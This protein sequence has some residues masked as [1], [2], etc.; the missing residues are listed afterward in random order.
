VGP[1]R[2]GQPLGGQGDPPGLVEGEGVGHVRK[3]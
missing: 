2:G 1:A 3:P